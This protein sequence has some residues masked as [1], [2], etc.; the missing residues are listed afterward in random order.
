[1]RTWREKVV[2]MP[3]NSFKLRPLCWFSLSLSSSLLSLSQTSSCIIV[4]CIRYLFRRRWRGII[5]VSEWWRCKQ[6]IGARAHELWLWIEWTLSSSSSYSSA[7]RECTFVTKKCKERVWIEWDMWW[8]ISSLRPQN[9][10]S[11]LGHA[12]DAKMRG[13]W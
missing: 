4:I 10:L 11:F 12:K 13:T 6:R 7:K 5:K 2:P 1:M 8:C 3:S 9:L